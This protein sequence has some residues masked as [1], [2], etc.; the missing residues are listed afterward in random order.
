MKKSIIRHPIFLTFLLAL[1]IVTAIVIP[2]SATDPAVYADDA[3]AAAAGYYFRV[4]DTEGTGYYNTLADAVTAV[5]EAGTIHVLASYSLS[6]NAADGSAGPTQVGAD[7]TENKTYTINGHGYTATL[8]GN[9]PYNFSKS[10]ATITNWNFVSSTTIGQVRRGSH[11]TFDSCTITSTN[12]AWG[13]FAVYGQATLNN[14]TITA[15]GTSAGN[16]GAANS[17]IFMTH[18]SGYGDSG[19]DETP[20]LTL[21]GTTALSSKLSAIDSGDDTNSD[22]VIF[23]VVCEGTDVTVEGQ[24]TNIL[25][26]EISVE[27]VSNDS[28]ARLKGYLFRA[29]SAYYSTLYDAVEAAVAGDQVV[30][31]LSN[32][33]LSFNAT[34]TKGGA[35]EIGSTWTEVKTY[36]IEGQG[37]TAT[38]SGNRPYNFGNSNVTINNFNIVSNTTIGQVRNGCTMTLNNCNF[39]CSSNGWGVL[40]VRA[41]LILNNSTLLATGTYN[42]SAP[43]NNAGL[44]LAPQKESFDWAE[45]GVPALVL[46]G[47]STLQSTNGCAIHGSDSACT[48]E[49]VDA[50]AT[51]SGMLSKMGKTVFTFPSETYAAGV[52][53]ITYQVDG[54]KY[55]TTNASIFTS[56]SNN[57]TIKMLRDDTYSSRVFVSTSDGVTAFT[58]DGNGHTISTAGSDRVFNMGNGSTGITMTMRN[59][60]LAQSG[61]TLIVQV[62]A[63]STVILDDGAALVYTGS[64]TTTVPGVIIQNGATLIMNEGSSITDPTA[65]AGNKNCS[66]VKFNEANA[67]FTF[68]G[69]ALNTAGYKVWAYYSGSTLNVNA[70]GITASSIVVDTA[71]TININ[72]PTEIVEA[73]LTLDKNITLHVYAENV[74]GNISKIMTAKVEMEDYDAVNLNATW[75]ADAQQYVFDFTGVLPQNM[76]N[77]I[78]VTL[79]ADGT[80]VD[81]LE[82]YT[83]AEYL[84]DLVEADGSSDAL[85]TLAVDLLYYGSAA[86]TYAEYK[87]TALAADVLTSEQKALRS[88]NTLSSYTAQKAFSG[89]ENANYT[90][91]SVSMTLENAF[92]LELKANVSSTENLTVEITINGNT[93]TFSGLTATDGVI[94]MQYD[95]ISA[96]ETTQ[97]ITAVIKVSD[98]QVGQTLTYSLGDYLKEVSETDNISDALADLVRSIYSYGVSAIA[99]QN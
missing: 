75:D 37:Y 80:E 61:T 82:N 74:Y 30:Y 32:Y 92:V 55:Y 15:T 40:A 73:S 98:A 57:G 78:T 11:V 49:V 91:D 12:N 66:L 38:L 50:T 63:N 81:K 56:V 24:V 85:K 31:V 17:C 42:S 21:K 25:A 20:T 95:N 16:N 71:G 39:T 76:R 65:V 33:T 28:M 77:A 51:I 87:T 79:Y 5:P 94:T 10:I 86:Q 62:M 58:L 89:D 83:I 2:A 67:T 48:V 64:S 97:A 9:R 52:T 99:Y 47:T 26:S 7:L 6:I 34:G 70:A 96:L 59:I 1:A 13:A 27:S 54:N 19:V 90:W 84:K 44:Y 18:Q 23:S 35:S 60:T 3:T 93:D 46:K 14:T 36:T 41:T 68:N 43:N 72:T 88:A 29:N 4:G 69:G 22:S 45:N 8:S 53:G